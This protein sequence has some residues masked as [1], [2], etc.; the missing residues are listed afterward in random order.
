MCEWRKNIGGWIRLGTLTQAIQ[1]YNIASHYIIE[2]HPS[3]ITKCITDFHDRICQSRMHVASGF[4]NEVT[5]LLASESFDG[6]LFDTY[7]LN[8]AELHRNHFE[9]F[10][11]AYRLLKPGGIFTYYSDE[12]TGFSEEHRGRL[13]AAGFTAIESEICEVEPP[14]SCEYWQHKTIL[15]PIIRK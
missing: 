5:P 10:S 8:A 11:E 7:P 1:S 14:A 3:V 6:I 9:F 13:K 12:A 2:C 15:V 4:W